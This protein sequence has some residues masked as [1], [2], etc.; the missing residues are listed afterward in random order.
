MQKVI[1]FETVIKE[2]TY[3]D[4]GVATEYET[5]LVNSERLAVSKL[6][7]FLQ[8]LSEIVENAKISLC[9]AAHS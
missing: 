7:V 4:A 1:I 5:I 3:N 6:P 9:C 2:I 8:K